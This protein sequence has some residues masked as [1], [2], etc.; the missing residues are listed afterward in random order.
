MM[1]SHIARQLA[2]IGDEVNDLYRR[3]FAGI[4]RDIDVTL[5]GNHGNAANSLYRFVY[6]G[7]FCDATVKRLSSLVSLISP[8]KQSS[9]AVDKQPQITAVLS[10]YELR[11]MIRVS[12]DI[13]R[14]YDVI[15][16]Q[17]RSRGRSETTITHPLSRYDVI[18]WLT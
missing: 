6:E 13:L 5:N 14:R 10:P 16:D 4:M 1:T 8:D 11:Q 3:E 9:I 15:A 12:E 17:P 7:L 18:S 2:I